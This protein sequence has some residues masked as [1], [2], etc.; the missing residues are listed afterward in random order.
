MGCG[1]RLVWLGLC[2]VG[3]SI[4]PAIRCV[5]HHAAARR[6]PVE[7]RFALRAALDVAVA[8][9]HYAM[10]QVLAMLDRSGRLRLCGCCRTVGSDL[11]DLA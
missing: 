1:H 5:E 11:G 4:A 8:A 3:L 7:Q 9:G 2:E 10:R 6:A